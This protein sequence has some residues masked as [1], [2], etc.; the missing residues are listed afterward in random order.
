MIETRKPDYTNTPA[1]AGRPVFAYA[2]G[3][4]PGG[5]EPQ[6][7]IVTPYFDTGPV[8]HET[9]G[10]VLGQSLQ[11]FEWLI[12]N[13][14]SRDAEALAILN[15]YRDRD[16]RVRVI[17]HETNRGLSAA[18]NTGFAAAR[19]PYV[20]QLDS[21]D[22]I[23][24]TAIEKCLWFLHS[25]PEYAFVKGYTVGFGG[26]QYLWTK[27]FHLGESF[28]NANLATATT[29]VRRD[30]HQAVGGY[31]EAL[32]HGMEDWDFW[33]RCAE[34]GWWG[35]TVPEY[36]D[37]YRRRADEPTPWANLET[38][39]AEKVFRKT[40]ERKYPGVY[41][42]RFPSI[43]P[44]GQA[45]FAPV[46]ESLPLAN[47]LAKDKPRILMIVPWFAMGGADKFNL[48]MIREL[49]N[50]GWE[51]TLAATMRHEHPWLAAFAA[52]TPDVFMLHHFVRPVDQPRF[53]RYLTETRQPDAVL[54]TN[55]EMGYLLLPYLRAYCPG[56]A[57][58][59]YCHMEEQQWKNGGYPRFA[60]GT[61]EWLDLNI[62]ASRHLKQWMVDRGADAARIEVCH[63]NV[64][65]EQWRP[66]PEVRRRVRDEL[67]L[68]ADEV[69][70]L[71]AGR[72]CAQ[73]Q[74]HVLAETARRLA[75]EGRGFR[76]LV[77][78]DGE[79]FEWLRA[80]V[81]KHRLRERVRL[82]GAVSS[83][84]VVELMA[85]S[86][87]FFLPSQWE[88]IALSIYEAMASGLVVVGAVVGGQAELVTPE[89]GVLLPKGTEAEE[90]DAY[91]RELSALLADGER[92][93]ALG[94]RARERVQAHF[95]LRAM[96]DGMASLLERARELAR[97][98]PRET[99]SRRRAQECATQAMEY[100]RMSDFAAWLWREREQQARAAA[101]PAEAA[102]APPT[103]EEAFYADLQAKAELE[104]IENSRFWR[105]VLRVRR[106]WLYRVWARWRY[107][108]GWERHLSHPDPRER[109]TRIKASRSYRL[110]QT[111]K[112]TPVYKVW[113]RI[114][115]GPEP[116]KAPWST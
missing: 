18:R 13:D 83:S 14:G 82:L 84:R 72:I 5:V 104:H 15:E 86:D 70:L 57:Y 87:I 17:D 109:L 66:R 4:G 2:P 40:L 9:A 112:R 12:V 50:R 8:F 98:A 79:D 27:G 69:V 36:L 25:Y 73:K 51:V 1:S 56:P 102:A 28:L 111:I 44:D 42:G 19:T 45:P 78:G 114:K 110:I 26:Q 61:Q 54:V 108:A 3:A 107:G 24:P 53:L 77:A 33:L 59:D 31:N 49:R 34:H 116:G 63:I 92:R 75:Y 23:E 21:D 58:V 16:P 97:T 115:H 65:T 95:E 38:R 94:R 100:L 80:F 71:F 37:W 39:D 89:C 85:A 76:M 96:G 46:A 48:D 32:R 29:M 43:E 106:T 90:A 41:G 68:D 91:A 55:S 6:V 35:G 67:K 52:E 81:D 60:V 30:V 74:P 22:L 99:I 10:C 64:D 101:N 88:G 93:A 103:K 11:A 105:A 113:A 20:F 47:P 7:T 62:V